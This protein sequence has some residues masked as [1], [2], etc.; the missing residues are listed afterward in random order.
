MMVSDFVTFL[1]REMTQFE[2]AVS[3]AL[4]EITVQLPV[5]S[6][7]G[8]VR[9]LKTNAS[10][11]F[12][13]LIDLTAVDYPERA[14]RFEVV[15]HFLSHKTGRRVRLKIQ[16]S[17]EKPVPSLVGLYPCA[18]WWEREA[19]DMFGLLFEGTHDHRRL[20]TDY[21]FEGHPLRKD[22]PVT[23]YV[24][25]IYD[26]EQKKVV[27]VPVSLTQERREFDFES[28]WEGVHTVVSRAHEAQK[29]EDDAKG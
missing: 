15:Y 26:E 3:A 29:G 25:S 12:E 2:G 10:C 20:L 17:P 21:G 6:F 7:L 13:Q 22:F 24:E 27:S 1:E 16:T 19:W 11:R 9:F 18:C 5:G 4:G 23:G 8:C 14:E 28:P